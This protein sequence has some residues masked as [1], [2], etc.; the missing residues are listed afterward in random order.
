MG[1]AGVEREIEIKEKGEVVGISWKLICSPLEL[2]AE[3]RDGDE[4]NWG[5]LFKLTNPDGKVIGMACPT[6]SWQ[7]TALNTARNC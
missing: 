7:A 2:I 6:A 4:L 5:K 1:P 3:T